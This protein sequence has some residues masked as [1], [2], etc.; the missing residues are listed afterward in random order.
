MYPRDGGKQAESMFAMIPSSAGSAQTAYSFPAGKYLGHMGSDASP[1]PARSLLSRLFCQQL[2]LHAGVTRQHPAPALSHFSH[3]LPAA[4]VTPCLR[5]ANLE[6]QE[7]NTPR[8]TPHR[9]KPV[10]SCSP[11]RPQ[12]DS[13]QILHTQLLG[14]CPQRGPA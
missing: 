6:V 4:S 9:W 13:P 2:W 12:V 1:A 11:S 14:H 10:E 7:V 3:F 5:P 8:G